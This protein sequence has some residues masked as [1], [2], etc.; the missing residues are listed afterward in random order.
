MAESYTTA[1]SGVL[2]VLYS[3]CRIEDVTKRN[4]CKR[5]IRER[6]IEVEVMR[7]CE[8]EMGE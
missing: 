8:I 4:L 3:N 7:S 1:L 6:L 5:E 2:G